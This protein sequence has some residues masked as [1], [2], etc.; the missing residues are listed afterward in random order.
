MNAQN[1]TILIS[2]A[3]TG[4]GL[5]AAQW[6]SSQGDHVIMVARNEQ[7]LKIEASRLK[8][9]SYIVCD[10]SN[11]SQLELLVKKVKEK[12]PE[13][14]MIFLN[15]GIATHYTLLDNDDAFEVSKK[16][17]ATNY[18]PVVYL[19]H[20]LEPLLASKKNASFIITTSGVA[21]VPDLSHPTYSATKAAL[22]NYIVGLRLVLLRK[23]SNIEVYELIAP[24]VDSPF[25]KAVK[26]DLKVSPESVIERLILGIKNKEFEIRPGLTQEIYTTYLRSPEE[27]LLLLNNSTGA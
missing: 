24:L 1:N 17:M 13:L 26:S 3:G 8:N 7:R 20:H 15:A 5:A 9:A 16:E 10:L 18:H 2:G 21:F 19:T 25:S 12:H 23:N 27:A 4:M 14:N 11:E 22:H 6:F